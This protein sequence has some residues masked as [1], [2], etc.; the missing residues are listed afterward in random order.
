MRR[1]YGRIRGGTSSST[2]SS[3][4]PFASAAGY[5]TEKGRDAWVEVRG[6]GAGGDPSQPWHS[7]DAN[8]DD[9]Y[10]PLYYWQLHSLLGV[11]QIETLIRRFY[12]KVFD[13]AEDMKDSPAL[14][15]KLSGATF[16]KVFAK[17]GTLEHHVATQTAFWVDSFGGGAA[18]HGGQHR[19]DFHHETNAHQVMNAAGATHWMRRMGDALLETSFSAIDLR[20][21][22]CIVEFLRTKV[23]LYARTGGWKFEKRDF[24]FTR[25][26]PDFIALREAKQE[27]EQLLLSSS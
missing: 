12:G 1:D 16:R 8:M 6:L 24:S 5:T 4:C 20:I 14:K 17:H 7:L 23:K 21:K 22:P 15:A 10:A 2:R 18:Y 25:R 3:G 13:V 11:A 9:P 19:L 27:Q 26:D